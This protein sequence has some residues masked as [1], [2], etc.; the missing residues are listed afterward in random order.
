MGPRNGWLQY[1]HFCFDFSPYL[2]GRCR[3]EVGIQCYLP[4][5]AAAAFTKQQVGTQTRTQALA[6]SLRG[7][8]LAEVMY[9]PAREADNQEDVI[10]I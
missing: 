7:G 8:L 5:T 3:N 1:H 10:C 9:I 6:T 4:F 2:D